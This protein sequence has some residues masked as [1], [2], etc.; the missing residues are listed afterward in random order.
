[1]DLLIVTA[2]TEEQQVVDAVLRESATFRGLGDHYVSIFD[3]DRGDGRIYRIGSASAHQMGATKMGAYCAPIFKDL[4]PEAAVLVGIAASADPSIA[5]LGDVPFSSH[6]LSFDDIAVEAGVLT[7]RTEGYPTHPEMRKAVGSLRTSVHT[8]VPWRNACKDT[9]PK[10]VKS[11]NELRQTKI[12]PPVDYSHPHIIVDVTAGGPFLI[13]DA[14]FRDTLSKKMPAATKIAISAPVHPKLVSIEMESHGFMN[15]AHEQGIQASVLKGISDDGDANKRQLEKQTG[16]FYRAYACSNAVLAVLHMLRRAPVVDSDMVREQRTQDVREVIRQPQSPSPARVIL[17]GAKQQILACPGVMAVAVKEAI[18]VF[19]EEGHDPQLPELPD[20]IA[21]VIRYVPPIS[22][23]VGPSAIGGMLRVAVGTDKVRSGLGVRVSGRDGHCEVLTTNH[24]VSRSLQQPTPIHVALGDRRVRAAV[25]ETD[26]LRDLALLTVDQALWEAARIRSISPGLPELGEEVVIHLPDA[27]VSGRISSVDGVASLR[28][29]ASADASMSVDEVFTIQTE[30]SIESGHSGA[31]VTTVL[32]IPIGLVVGQ[33]ALHDSEQLVLGVAISTFLSTRELRVD[34]PPLRDKT[35]VVVGVLVA[36]DRDLKS[37]LRLL[38]EPEVQHDSSGR[39]YWASHV[40]STSETTVI[41]TQTGAMGNVAAALGAMALILHARPD[42]ILS[43]GLA[44]GTRTDV[45]LGDVVV[46]DSFA[47]L[48][49]GK[50]TLDGKVIRRSVTQQG[51]AIARSV[52]GQAS[53][54]SLRPDGSEDRYA[55]HVGPV[56][57]ID[58][59]NENSRRFFAEQRR[60][61]AVEME[62]AGVLAAAEQERIPY[63]SV[64][65]VADFADEAKHDDWRPYASAAAASTA[66]E[67]IRQIADAPHA[68]RRTR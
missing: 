24:V 49:A 46:S 13:R 19:V 45:G 47:S 37:L 44:G 64:R 1:M 22:L 9:I 68:S 3:F 6:V 21:M 25:L 61:L 33:A 56:G 54:R 48:E 67:I 11:L 60:T 14:E 65:G 30:G 58:S 35:Q 62:S 20:G 34:L 50:G 2:L 53:A 15:A 4:S 10:V 17:D 51:L 42:W 66:I 5:S 28:T 23:A 31:L 27:L 8:Y 43:V 18:V 41:V 55:V 38:H 57:S 63:L 36:S 26:R 39:T 29:D 59:L 12:T 7:F 52:A 16:G 32:G 40:P